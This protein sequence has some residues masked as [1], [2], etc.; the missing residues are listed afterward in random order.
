MNHQSFVIILQLTN[1]KKE[2]LFTWF[3]IIFSVWRFPVGGSTHFEEV[4]Q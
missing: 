3:F 4:S 2:S 1:T